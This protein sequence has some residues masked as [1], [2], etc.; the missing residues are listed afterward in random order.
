MQISI[1]KNLHPDNPAIIKGHERVRQKFCKKQSFKYHVW[2]PKQN[3][4]SFFATPIN[5]TGKQ[6]SKQIKSMFLNIVNF[7]A[8]EYRLKIFYHKWD[9]EMKVHRVNLLLMRILS[10]KE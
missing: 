9:L 1:T 3:K 10:E 4:T 5:E 2:K 6:I 8:F 7:S